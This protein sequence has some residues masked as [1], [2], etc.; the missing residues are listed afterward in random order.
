MNIRVLAAVGLMAAAVAAAAATQPPPT[1][2]AG[3]KAVLRLTADNFFDKVQVGMTRDEVTKLIGPPTTAKDREMTFIFDDPYNPVRVRIA[4]DDRGRVAAKFYE[5]RGG[6]VKVATEPDDAK[7]LQGVW[8]AT[9]MAVDGEPAPAKTLNR[10]RFIFKGEK[11]LFRG[12]FEND[13]E[14]ECTFKLDLK[15]SPKQLDIN[16]GKKDGDENVSLGIY[17]LKGDELRLCSRVAGSP[18]GRPAEFATAPDSGL[19]LIVFKRQKPETAEEA[20]KALQGAWAAAAMEED[21][22]PVPEETRQR[23]RMTFKGDKVVVRTGPLDRPD[24][25]CSYKLDPA[26]WPRLLDLFPPN[27]EGPVLCI[28][29]LSGDTLKLCWRRLGNS[30]GRPAAFATEQNSDLILFTL[31]REKPEPP[32]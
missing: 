18:K 2:K 6:S 19:A 9:S 10:V 5:P 31:N 7:L 13:K 26:T 32:K 22:R 23:F 4:L 1:A 11:L 8:V 16:F 27:E 30:K 25:E 17:E 14:V 12:N 29:E 20:A 15:A 21:G 28:Y 3:A 24:T